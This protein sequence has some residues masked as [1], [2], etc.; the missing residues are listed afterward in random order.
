MAALF[1]LVSVGAPSGLSQTA[2]AE[3]KSEVVMTRLYSPAYPPLARQAGIMGDVRLQLHIR[4]DGSI[5]SVDVVSGHLMLKQAALDSAQKSQFE[6]HACAAETMTYSLTYTFAIGKECRNDPDCSGLNQHP[7]E[8]GQ[9][10]GFVTI[11]VDPL[12]TCDP[13]STITR[14]KWRSAKCLY[15]WHCASRVTDEK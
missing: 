4:Q 5:E 6:C 13:S 7:P 2:D 15:L 8:I 12:C 3:P 1:N 11:T 14:L 10:P 9:S